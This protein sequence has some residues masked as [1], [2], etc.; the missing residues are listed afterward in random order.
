MYAFQVC[1]YSKTGKTTLSR[2]LISSLRNEG[3]RVA[4]I[5]DIHAKGFHIDTEGKDT[6]VH[7]QAGASPVVAR[8]LDETDFLYNQQMDFLEIMSKISADWLIVEGLNDFPLPKIACGKEESDLN[9]FVDGR[10]FAVSGVFSQ[11][12]KHFKG[13][14]VFDAMNRS[15]IHDLVQLIKNKVFPV[16]PYLDESSCGKCGITCSEMVEALMK[17]EKSYD[18]CLVQN[19][20]VRLKIGDQDI[21]LNPFVQKILQNNV[22]GVVSE[23]RG[24]DKSKRVIVTIDNEWTPVPHGEREAQK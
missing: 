10:T 16:L 1:G 13:F 17:G 4:S 20:P 15:D 11:K 8:G 3:Y 14:R 21:P 19:K 23:L 18:E 2:E 22:L 7:W 12:H 5:K 24:W 6:F 9:I